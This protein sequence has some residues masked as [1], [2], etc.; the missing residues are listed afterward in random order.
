MSEPFSRKLEFVVNGE[1]DDIGITVS[2]D[3][4]GNKMI[5]NTGTL[6]LIGKPPGT[7]WT[8]LM[9]FAN[10]ADT[11]ITVENATGW[12]VGDELG[13]APSFMG[14]KEF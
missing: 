12:K 7:T 5:V 2:P 1:K 14:Q 13:I 6:E 4:T 11:T 10:V 9:E 8:R 3:L